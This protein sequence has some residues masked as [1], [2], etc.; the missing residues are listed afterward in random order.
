M[1]QNFFQ[2]LWVGIL[3]ISL[4]KNWNAL[5]WDSG[6][7]QISYLS[8]SRSFNFVVIVDVNV[9]VILVLLKLFNS[10]VGKSTGFNFLLAT[11]NNTL[12]FCLFTTRF[13]KVVSIWESKKEIY[14]YFYYTFYFF[15]HM[16][17]QYVRKPECAKLTPCL[18]H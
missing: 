5:I 10:D 8:F 6:Q 7:E 14:P 4:C 9:S 12:L 17:N 15:L 1:A 18:V 16:K 2:G 11:T 13:N 3:I